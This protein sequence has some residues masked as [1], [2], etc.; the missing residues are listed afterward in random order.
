MENAS[1]AL[2]I[3]GGV[4]VAILLISLIVFYRSQISGLMEAKDSVQEFEQ[5]S[6]FNKQFDVYY[7]DKVYGS[8]ILSL[9][10]KINDYNDKYYKTG[11]YVPLRIQIQ[12]KNTYYLTKLQ[13]GTEKTEVLFQPKTYIEG[14][15]DSKAK[16]TEISTPIKKLEN[17]EKTAS[18]IQTYTV[19]EN[20][21]TSKIQTSIA[22]LSGYRDNEITQMFSY[23]QTLWNSIKSQIS[24]YRKN[25][26]VLVTFKE[27]VFRADKFEY[28]TANGTESGR[29][30]SMSFVQN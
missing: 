2:M 9:V 15:T 14:Y 5:I 26:T 7:R 25:H 18:T 8:E 28:D 16:K 1:K 17:A 6:E 3:A 20:G 30:K 4:L 11:N 22:S 12:L 29:I 10:N 27:K 23:N 21:K 13:G 24:V 19:K